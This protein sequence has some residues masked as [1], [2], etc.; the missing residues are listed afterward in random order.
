MRNRPRSRIIAH[1]ERDGPAPLRKRRDLDHRSSRSPAS[2]TD[3]S[4]RAV[5]HTRRTMLP[6][7]RDASGIV[8]CD[9]VVCTS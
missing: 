9:Y 5:I 8:A 6:G 3:R 1:D 4:M 2:G 7:G